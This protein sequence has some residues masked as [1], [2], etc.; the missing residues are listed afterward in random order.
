MRPIAVYSALRIGLFLVAYV[1][2]VALGAQGLL[3]LGLAAVVSLGLSFVLL[4][5]QR[6]SVAQALLDRRTARP[7]E[8]FSQF[9]RADAAAEDAAA[10]AVRPAAPDRSGAHPAPPAG[11]SG[12]AQR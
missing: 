2:L 3:A 6:E 11:R 10:D 8:G 9:L 5:R 12:P 4:R 7:R 1:A